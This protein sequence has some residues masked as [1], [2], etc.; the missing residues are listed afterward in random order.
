MERKIKAEFAKPRADRGGAKRGGGGRNADFELSPK[1]EGCI[2]VFV[3]KLSYDI[4]EETMRDTFKD[5]GD[6]KEIRWLNDRETGQFKGCAFVEFSSTGAVDKAVKLNGS[7]VMGRAMK[8]DFA[9]N[10]RN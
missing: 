10:K 6:I 1:P 5:C 2:T 7:S 4:D 8:I 3:G 9:S